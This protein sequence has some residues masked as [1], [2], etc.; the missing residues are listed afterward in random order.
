M[1]MMMAI[2]MMNKHKHND[3]NQYVLTMYHNHTVCNHDIDD[4]GG[5]SG[6]SG[7]FVGFDQDPLS[8]V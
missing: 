7:D 8:G 3:D 6:C 1:V 5:A 2:I 4:D